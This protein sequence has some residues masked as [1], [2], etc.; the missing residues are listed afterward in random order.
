V[1]VLLKYAHEIRNGKLIV[2]PGTECR[3][4]ANLL[5][6][7][8]IASQ[9][10]DLRIHFISSLMQRNERDGQVC[11]AYVMIRSIRSEMGRSVMADWVLVT[12]ASS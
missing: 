11:D 2:N 12:M 7:V 4:V 3:A 6:L 8:P 5:L 9:C 10:F 1:C